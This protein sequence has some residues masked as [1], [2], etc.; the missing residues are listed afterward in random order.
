MKALDRF[1]LSRWPAARLGEA[2]DAV[3]RQSGARTVTGPSVHAQNALGT[4]EPATVFPREIGPWIEAAAGSLGLECDPVLIQYADCERRLRTLGPALLRLPDG[5][6]V[7]LLADGALLGPDLMARRVPAL[8]LRSAL[9]SEA[10]L[11]VSKEVDEMIEAAGIRQR[12]RESTRAAMMTDLL[13][14]PP[15]E[16]CWILRAPPGGSFWR[17]L[18]GARVPKR[19][20]LLAGA[21]LTEY[22]L[23]IL[24]WWMV[25]QGALEGRLDR[26]WLLGWVLLLLTLVPFRVATTWLQGHIAIAGGGLMRERLLYGALRLDPDETRE[27]GVGQLLGRVIESE[28]LESL[29]LSGGFLALVSLLELVLAAFVLAAGAGGTWQVILLVCWTVVTALIGWRY[30]R[31]NSRWTDER[32]G[33]THDLVERMIGHRTRLAQ[34]A[35]EHWHDGEDQAL[36]SYLRTSAGMD[37]AAAYLTALAPRGWLI[38]AVAALAPA[39]VSGASPAALAVGLGGSLLG[40]RAFKRLSAGLWHLT[41]AAIAW[42]QVSPLFRAAERAEVHGSAAVPVAH[43]SKGPL[44]EA[45]DLVFRYRSRSEPVLRGCSL[46]IKSGDRFV[47]EGASGGGKSTLASLLVG[48][49]NPESGLLLVGGL[50]RHTL[51]ARRWRQLV[52]AAPQFHEN[53]VLT[54]SFAFNLF[55]GR[56]RLLCPNDFEEAEAV[57]RELGLGE[58]IARM[59]GGLLQLVGETGWQLS[60]GERSRLYIARA[61]LQGAD[62]IVLD[63]SFGALDPENLRRAV[64]CVMK[65]AS[66]VLAIAHP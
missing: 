26:G 43:G 36:D 58:L 62:L 63:E 65:R 18:C 41:G 40:F 60:H 47:L 19:L 15:V 14:P 37:R 24:A 66:T 38:V 1:K 57:C 3:A 11:R 6:F 28:A 34:E 22:L 13:D 48:L 7:A 53:H 49:R 39:F 8:I 52:A 4:E 23:W 42:R 46:Q 31:G 17:Q 12:R 64:E 44:V 25:G 27:Q 20:L 45:H 9:Y 54:G 10:E 33:M 56:Q 32:L 30:F 5:D 51:G 35:R 16:N 61:L 59:P 50:D 29:A 55:L 2:L 21:H